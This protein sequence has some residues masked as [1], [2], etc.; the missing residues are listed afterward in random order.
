ML[1]AP[2]T[3]PSLAIVFH[4]YALFAEHQYQAILRSPEVARL[5][6]YVDR[7]TIELEQVDEKL[8]RLRPMENSGALAHHQRKARLLLDQDKAQ[9]SV[10][11]DA[12]AKFL[13]DAILMYSRCL[14]MSD[15]YDSD[16]SIHLCSLWFSN[17][18][19]DDLNESI[20]PILGAIPS[21]KFVFLAHQLSARISSSD[22]GPGKA[23]RNLQ[24]VMAR[25]CREHPFHSLY[26][27]YLLRQNGV[28]TTRNR[29]TSRA[30]DEI[31]SAQKDRAAAAAQLFQSLRHDASAGPRVR[32]LEALCDAY[33]EWAQFPIKGVE[34]FNAQ[35]QAKE[36]FKI[37]QHL[38][39]R[40]LTN[41][42]VP[43]STLATPVDPTCR[44][45]DIISISRYSEKFSTAGGINLPKITDCLGS[46]GDRYKQLVR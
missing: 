21:R 22:Q 35:K 37:P 27:V 28:D 45:E 41:L 46:D 16:A 30:T 36:Q 1:D 39:I 20:G 9:Y 4:R 31:P 44:Y 38:K 24:S 13:L 7:K 25:L 5:K 23:Q 40:K 15:E 33:L 10:H 8:K 14:V 2:S 29:R 42:Q 6:L 11:T 26:Q 19:S 32:D 17:F 43:V 34:Q 18:N 12:R 3:E